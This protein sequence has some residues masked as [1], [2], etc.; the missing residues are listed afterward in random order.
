[1]QRAS[2]F[3]A[4]IIILLGL[5]LIILQAGCA[6]SD[7]TG[8][9][10]GDTG[11]GEA[12]VGEDAGG[13]GGDFTEPRDTFELDDAQ[14]DL[15]AEMPEDDEPFEEEELEET[16]GTIIEDSLV[17]EDIS[18]ETVTETGYD[19]GYRIQVFAS[20]DLD[21]AEAIKR[22][23]AARTA[24]PA[25]IAYE[26]GLY[27]VRVGD[28]MTREAASAARS[29]LADVYPDCWIVNTTIRK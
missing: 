21:N 11:R 17:V 7:I 25:Y 8:G 15:E 14:Y 2:K 5:V 18:E 23:A 13:G 22:E 20:S 19:L 16:I 4:R 24:L 9:V 12:A 1:M 6:K 3:P 27:K 29:A 26:G 10:R 28:F